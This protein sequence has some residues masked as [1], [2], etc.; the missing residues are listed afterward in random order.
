[1][2]R[3]E[4]KSIPQE[5]YGPRYR[6]RCSHPI[7]TKSAEIGG[8]MRGSVELRGMLCGHNVPRRRGLSLDGSAGARGA[9]FSSR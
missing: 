7:G 1:M 4:K 3:Q 8:I 5:A 9:F 2:D 6:A